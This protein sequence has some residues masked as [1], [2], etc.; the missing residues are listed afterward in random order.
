MLVKFKIDFKW[1]L[2]YIFA[3]IVEVVIIAVIYTFMPEG[4]GLIVAKVITQ[5]LL[6]LFP[7]VST[8]LSL[9]LQ[10]HWEKKIVNFC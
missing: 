7:I 5:P 6:V 2:H 4:K 3:V 1:Y 8:F 9:L 10:H